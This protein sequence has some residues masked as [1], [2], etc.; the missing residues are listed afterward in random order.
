[1]TRSRECQQHD[2][3]W[4]ADNVMGFTVDMSHVQ[5]VVYEHV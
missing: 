3:E 2:D 1:M 5:R 4:L